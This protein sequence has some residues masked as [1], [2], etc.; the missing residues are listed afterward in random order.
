MRFQVAERNVENAEQR[1]GSRAATDRVARGRG[2][3]RISFLVTLE[4]RVNTD[5][6]S[7]IG[8]Q[9][10]MEASRPAPNR[11][12]FGRKNLI[13]RRTSVHI[14]TMS[15]GTY[16]IPPQKGPPSQQLSKEFTI[17]RDLFEQLSS[18]P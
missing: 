14:Y 13:M 18:P 10:F 11:Q 16:K 17:K 6:H 9:H 4:T 5:S 1:V 7:E 15:N 3:H 8:T 2:P 12:R